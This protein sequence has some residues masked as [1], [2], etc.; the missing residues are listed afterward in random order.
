MISAPPPSPEWPLVVC[1]VMWIIGA[2]LVAWC[3]EIV[4]LWL[5]GPARNHRGKPRPVPRPELSMPDV[6]TSRLH[7]LH[8]P[9]GARWGTISPNPIPTENATR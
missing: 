6:P 2:L 9:N 3:V 5:R 1:C 4:W 8:W 7:S